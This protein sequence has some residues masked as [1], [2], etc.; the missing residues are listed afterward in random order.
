MRLWYLSHRQPGKVQAR[1]RIHAVSP[2]PSLFAHRKYE[3]RLSVRPK[4]RHMPHRMAANV[5]LKNESQP[6]SGDRCL[7]FGR[8][9]LD[10]CKCVFEE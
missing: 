2:E 9:P 4:T 5:C 6:S 1:L 10:G 3:S 8:A 7:V